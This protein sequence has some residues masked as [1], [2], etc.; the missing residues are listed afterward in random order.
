MKYI[1]LLLITVSFQYSFGQTD[2]TKVEKDTL[3]N[4]LLGDLTK[5]MTENLDYI[6]T[7]PK[8][9]KEEL[10]QNIDTNYANILA[11]KTFFKNLIPKDYAIFIEFKPKDK[12]LKLDEN[13]DFRVYRKDKRNNIVGIV[14][15][16]TNIELKSSKLDSL[17]DLTSLKRKDLKDLKEY[18]DKAK[19]ISISNISEFEIG[20]ARS[21]MG[22]YSYLIFD[23]TLNSYD[24]VKYNDGC[25]YIFLRKNI[26]LEYV[27]GLIDPKCFP[28][29]E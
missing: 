26:V 13:I 1:L 12:F 15:Y 29:N 17:L 23:K 10:I 21:G 19:C 25:K 4:K 8:S 3:L 9:S 28:E 7:L 11:L 14:I 20:F 2:S 18:L 16:E 27:G 5:E 24:Q 22:K 6:P